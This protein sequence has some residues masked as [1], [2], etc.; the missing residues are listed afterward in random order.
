[1]RPKVIH[2]RMQYRMICGVS[3]RMHDMSVASVNQCLDCY[4]RERTVRVVCRPAH[5]LSLPIYNCLSGV[6]KHVVHGDTFMCISQFSKRHGSE[7]VTEQSPTHRHRRRHGDLDAGGRSSCSLRL[8]R[9]LLRL[10][11]QRQSD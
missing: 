3:Y 5:S 11:R 6:V 2:C 9:R 1:M 7:S 8:T 10:P 4:V